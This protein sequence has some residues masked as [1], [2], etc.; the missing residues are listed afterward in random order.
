MSYIKYNQYYPI[1]NGVQFNY[2]TGFCLKGL[3]LNPDESE[4]IWFST[5]QCF[6][7]LPPVSSHTFNEYLSFDQHVS[8]VY[9]TCKSAY[10]HLRTL[11]HTRSVVSEYMAKSVAVPLVSSR[12]DYENFV[13]FGTCASNL[14]ELQPVQNTHAKMLLNNSALPSATVLRQSSLAP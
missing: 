4:A 1:Q 10:F 7:P 13:L 6:A 11:R 14:H 2:I 5:R 3:I 9:A 8:S 12:L